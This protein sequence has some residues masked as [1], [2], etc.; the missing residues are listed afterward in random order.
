M[1]SRP[2]PQTRADALARAL[3]LDLEIGVCHACLSFV[4][5]AL[6]DGDPA[7]IAR[8][9]RGMTPDLWDDGLAEPALAAVR[10]ARDLRVPDAEAAL[11]DLERRGGRS[12]VARSIV[13]RLAEDL[14]RRTHTEMRLEALARDR[15][16]S[17]PPELN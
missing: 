6:A 10:H 3:D 4:S 14:R 5:F 2:L 8:Q 1:T 11:A 16:R 15:L 7:E 17:A 12:P 13:R 9:V